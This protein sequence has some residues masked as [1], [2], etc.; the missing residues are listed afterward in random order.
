MAIENGS[1]LGVKRETEAG[2]IFTFHVSGM[3]AV[4]VRILKGGEQRDALALVGEYKCGGDDLMVV[5]LVNG[6]QG[7]CSVED[8][9]GQR[10]HSYA[11]VGVNGGKQI[12]DAWE[13]G[14]TNLDDP[15]SF[16][17]SD[18]WKNKFAVWVGKRFIGVCPETCVIVEPDE[19]M[20]VY[21]VLVANFGNLLF[22]SPLG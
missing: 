8:S 14:P 21:D 5:H 16:G 18:D 1:V 12:G 10:H 7:K 22:A 4:T 11:R 19:G 13:V 6:G 9:T 2:R 17:E 3:D 20:G 15:A